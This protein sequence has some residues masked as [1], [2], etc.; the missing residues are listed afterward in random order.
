MSGP[1]RGEEPGGGDSATPQPPPDKL[2]LRIAGEAGRLLADRGGDSRR[3]R[4]RAAR[5]VAHGWVPPWHLPD[6]DEI[7]RE[8]ARRLSRSGDA[9]AARP[10]P[11]GDRFDALAE[12]VRVLGAVRRDPA[13]Y[14][15]GDALEHSLQVFARVSDECPWDE[16]L[17]TAALVHDV[18]LAIDRSDPVAATL[19][20]VA[21]LVTERTAWFVEM[22]PAAAALHAGTLGLRARH[23]LEAHPDF[24]ALG[25]LAAADRRAHVRGG[26]APSLEEAVQVLRDLEAGP[27]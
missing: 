26:E 7:R 3:A 2:R 8:T 17:L 11:P 12:M 6:G 10:G 16:E 20:A 22:L 9:A 15:E 19:E 4:Y 21:G 27:A 14:P 5:S 24:E 25:V 18:G 13:R 23:R 1:A